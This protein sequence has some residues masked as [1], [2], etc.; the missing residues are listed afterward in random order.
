MRHL[1]KRSRQRGPDK[2][3]PR[4]S[5]ASLAAVGALA[6]A[7]LTACG[8]DGSSATGSD[9]IWPAE[10]PES[11]V[12]AAMKEGKVDWYTVF[13]EENSAPIIE[14]F[15]KAY[16]GFEVSTLRLSANQLSSRIMTEQRGGQFSADVVSG[17]ATYIGQLQNAGAM[18]G[19]DIPGLPDAPVGLDL[20]D[21]HQGIVYI[22]TTVIAYNPQRLKEEGLTAPTSWEDLTK[23]EWKGKFSIDPESVD[24]YD[25]LVSSMGREEALE[26][27]TA[28]GKNSPRI[29]PNHTQ[30]LTEMQGGETVAAATA[31]GPASASFV[32]EDP[33][34]TAF[35]NPNPL[36]AALTL[37]GIAK[38]PPHPAAAKLFLDWLLSPEGQQAVVDGAGKISIRDDVENDP[39]LWDTAKWKPAWADPSRHPEEYNELT[40]EFEEAVN[41]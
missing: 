39:S 37:S 32:E 18:Q 29:T 16:P 31:Y 22:N 11:L 17:N 33:E 13:T 14:A 28:L 38:E 20:P 30:Q 19:Y 40:A 23:P 36:P 26:L 27:V 4:R 2:A 7:S 34:R 3:G 15:M 8:G 9:E 25:S 10:S 35:V 21:G 6:L 24:W 41:P 1:C 12:E 5:I